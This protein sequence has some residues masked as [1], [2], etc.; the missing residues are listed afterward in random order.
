MR[1]TIIASIVYLI[2]LVLVA[3]YIVILSPAIHKQYLPNEKA[4]ERD[5]IFTTYFQSGNPLE[6]A[7][8]R[9]ITENESKHMFD[10]RKL[11]VIGS[12]LLLGLSI[13]LL[14]LWEHIEH[15]IVVLL[16]PLAFF[17]FIIPAI[18]YSHF[19]IV[20]EWFHKLFFPQGNYTF[21][22][23]SVLITTYP[24][25]FFASMSSLIISYTLG[26]AILF[27][28]MKIISDKIY[29]LFNKKKEEKVVALTS[30][31]KS[32]R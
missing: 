22:L 21:P 32:T 20:F 19:D 1:R 12:F 11:I 25:E 4:I 6:I 27:L 16:S 2:L 3:A 31:N 18:G 13:L 10:V 26:M 23:N 24:A 29:N 14:W 7:N 17:T 8:I 30:D 9:G 28:A 15:R 5:A